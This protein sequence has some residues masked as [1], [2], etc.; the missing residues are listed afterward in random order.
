MVALIAAAPYANTGNVPFITSLDA[1]TSATAVDLATRLIPCL[2]D[3]N[4]NIT[5]PISVA[6]LIAPEL[7][8][9]G[10]MMTLDTDG[11]IAFRPFFVPAKTTP[12]SATLTAAHVVTPFGDVGMWPGW[13]PAADGIISIVELT[14][15]KRVD[16]ALSQHGLLQQVSGVGK[17]LNASAQTTH[18]Y[19]DI[20]SISAHKNRG[21][22]TLKIEPEATSS[23]DLTASDAI[24]IAE[25]I[26]SFFGRPYEV[27]T[28]KVRRT[29]ATLALRCSSVIALTSEHV[30]NS[31]DGT[32]GVTSR[33]CLVI[34]RGVSY[35][36][37]EDGAVVSLTLVM[38]PT[39]DGTTLN[40]A[41]YAGSALTT[42][43]TDL[44]GNLWD[45]AITAG[46]YAPTG[47]SDYEFFTAGDY[48]D[49]IQ[50]N[51]STPNTRTG[52]VISTSALNI[53]V[54]FTG[55]APWGGAWAADYVV[56]FADVSYGM[57]DPQDDYCYTADSGLL[58]S[59]GNPA[60][61]ML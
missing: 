36:P 26:V 18:L 29:A 54:Q 16:R 38:H 61:V 2:T 20:A 5:E 35:D 39:E 12:V 31:G 3:R 44:G 48:V 51:D 21:L 11:K 47:S 7:L 56:E 43:A 8:L 9:L 14:G 40:I 57:T 34:G 1:T 58:L 52:L 4:Y 28:L 27:V 55:A 46:T 53:R 59:N 10:M 37:A 6:D 23:S 24:S 19:R 33:R 42:G 13:M 15:A 45:I 32:R 17:L 22:C 41:G 60:R 50:I 25:R 30:P 49:V